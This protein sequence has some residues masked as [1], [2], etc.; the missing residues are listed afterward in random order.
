M[1]PPANVTNV[2]HWEELCRKIHA[3]AVESL[4]GRAGVIETARTMSKLR[5]WA[6]LTDDPDLL[7]FDGIDS[8]TGTLPV[9]DVRRF[10]LPMLWLGTTMT[11]T[12]PSSFTQPRQRK[13]P[14]HWLSGILGRW[15]HD[16]GAETKVPA[17]YATVTRK[18]YVLQPSAVGRGCVKTHRA[19][20][21]P[22]RACPFRGRTFD[23]E[24]HEDSES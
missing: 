4:E 15:T 23:S 20:E 24:H 16:V 7:T 22:E 17:S 1:Q 9:G 5:I 6:A 18:H 3:R 2:S 14:P 13:L 10:G 21:M 11:S 12:A 19:A 8:E